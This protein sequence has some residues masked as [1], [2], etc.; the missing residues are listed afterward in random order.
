MFPITK[1]M[2]DS[3]LASFGITDITKATIRQM[4]S[5][6]AELE[7]TAGEDF[8]HLEIGN[9]GLPAAT[10]GVEA[11]CAAL[12]GGIA[13]Q[14]PAIQGIPVLKENAA[15]FTKAFLDV[16]LKPEFIIPTVGS[17]QGLSL[18]HI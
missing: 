12:R 15:K 5:V 1:D 16:D 13:N 14:Y 8:I 10:I 9:P 7:K 4:C 2:L 17:M 18:I 11:E 6:A 3:V